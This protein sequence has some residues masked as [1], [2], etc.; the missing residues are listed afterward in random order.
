MTK[1]E[2]ITAIAEVLA[3]LQVPV[4]MGMPLGAAEQPWRN[5][6]NELPSGWHE[7]AE[8]ETMLRTR[9]D[10]APGT[11]W[12]AFARDM[13][14]DDDTALLERFSAGMR[15]MGFT[16]EQI[17]AGAQRLMDAIDSGSDEQPDD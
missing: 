15:E 16:D 4:S 8:Y 2:I 12:P 17:E 9:L 14:A 1:D 3:G 11:D 6:H 7:V 13:I 10:I 5:L